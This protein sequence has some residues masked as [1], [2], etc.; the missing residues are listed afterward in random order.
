MLV[1][2]C[3]AYYDS[4]TYKIRKAVRLNTFGGGSWTFK[5]NSQQPHIHIRSVLNGYQASYCISRMNGVGMVMDMI[6]QKTNA[7]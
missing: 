4:A 7:L 2:A 1:D 5:L 3:I 6:I